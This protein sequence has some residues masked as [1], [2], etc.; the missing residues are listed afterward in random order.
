MIAGEIDRLWSDDWDIDT[1]ILS[2]GGS[3]ELAQYL[4]PLI[5]GN[6][7][8]VDLSQDPR[9][10]NVLGY[11]KYGRYIWGEAEEAS[12]PEEDESESP[13]EPANPEDIESIT[14]DELSEM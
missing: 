13:P 12:L 6:V 1:I 4:Q 7:V 11:I 14:E 2:G 5:T 9:L 3:R 8:P 10:N